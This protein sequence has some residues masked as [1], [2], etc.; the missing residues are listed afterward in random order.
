M[1][2]LKAAIIGCGAIARAHIQPIRDIASLVAV[3]DLNTQRADDLAREFQCTPY[4]S[5]AEL[6]E[7]ESL[8]VVHLLTPHHVRVEVIQQLVNSGI[9]VLTEKPVGMNLSEGHKVSAIANAN[10]DVKIGV[11]LQ[12]RF[13]N[14]TVKLKELLQQN[15][16][17]S[18]H[19]IRGELTWNRP[20]SYYQNGPWRGKKATA[21]GGVLINQALHILDLIQLF[22][23]EIQSIKSSTNNFRHSQLDIEDTA[24]IFL[25]FSNGISGSLYATTNN[26]CDSPVELEV[27]G[28]HGRLLIQNYGLWLDTGDNQLEKICDDHSTGDKAYY[29]GSH[30]LAIQN[31]YQ[32]VVNKTDDFI[33][34]KTALKSLSIIDKVY[35]SSSI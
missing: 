4:Y 15:T 12:N 29:G 23:G 31:F 18:L 9:H 1:T 35:E 26:G 16:I 22:G 3:C 24:N 2:A 10:P 33:S 27:S 6:L 30:N 8:D 25:Q 17:G 34:V 7:S 13:N 32:S 28:A 11:V 21:G 14:T 19:S 5:V 20:L